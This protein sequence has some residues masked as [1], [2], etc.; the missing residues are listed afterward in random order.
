[1]DES[2]IEVS[3]D[4]LSFLGNNGVF[5][6]KRKIVFSLWSAVFVEPTIL[7]ILVPDLDLASSRLSVAGSEVSSNCWLTEVNDIEVNSRDELLETG[8]F[9]IAVVPGDI[10][11][12]NTRLSGFFVCGIPV[13]VVFSDVVTSGEGEEKKE[14]Q[15][16]HWFQIYFINNIQRYDT[17][18]YILFRYS[19]V[20]IQLSTNI[21]KF[22]FF[23]FLFFNN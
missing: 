8:A 16:F 19:F 3:S 7:D 6:G 23:I 12:W 11:K 15:G 13:F 18:I 20:I 9:V 17:N 22:L 21:T 1:M 10:G 4:S 2:I 14:C 5:C